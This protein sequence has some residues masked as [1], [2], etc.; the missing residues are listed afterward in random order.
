MSS[1]TKFPKP[2]NLLL[3]LLNVNTFNDDKDILLQKISSQ[4]HVQFFTEINCGS[5]ER[6]NVILSDDFYNWTLIPRDSRFAQR[7]GVRVPKSLSN[8]VKVIVKD[9]KYITQ[10]TRS[11]GQIDKSVVQLLTLEVNAFHLFYRIVVVYRV[12]DAKAEATYEMYRYIDAM[13]PHVALGDINIDY[14]K[15]SEFVKVLVSYRILWKNLSC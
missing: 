15:K 6:E 7:I 10:E 4:H 3:S 5:V 2:N 8:F 11:S 9:F 12:P 14:A 13:N 1:K